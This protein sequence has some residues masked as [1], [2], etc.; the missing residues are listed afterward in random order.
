MAAQLDLNFF[1][2]DQPNRRGVY[3]D[4]DRLAMPRGKGKGAAEIWI[5]FV[6]EGFIFGVCVEIETEGMAEL[7]SDSCVKYGHVLP[8]RSEAISRASD[9][10]R[11]FCHRTKS[12][13]SSAIQIWLKTIK[14]SA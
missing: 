10:I 4:C 9:R 11:R 2:Y 6:P 5:A 7:P 14:E 13:A 3:A 1:G 8:S 12:K